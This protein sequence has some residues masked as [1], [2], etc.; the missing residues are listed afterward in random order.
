MP[1]FLKSGG[2]GGGYGRG[3]DAFGARDI[4]H[5]PDAAPVWGGSGATEPEE[6]WD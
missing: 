5:D 2:G 6:S 4:R 3:G 1:E